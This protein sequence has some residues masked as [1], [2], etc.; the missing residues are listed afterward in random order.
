[1]P[2]SAVAATDL[3]QISYLRAI[4]DQR[5]RRGVRFP[6][7]YLLLLAVLGIYCFAEGSRLERLPEPARFVAFCH[8]PPQ[9][10]DRGA[11]A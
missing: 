7:W 3:N 11:G 2:E 1:V 8:P 9:R 4:Q 10:P 6:A 5:M